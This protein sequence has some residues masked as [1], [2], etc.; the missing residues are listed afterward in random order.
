MILS[1][2]L[3]LAGVNLRIQLGVLIGP[4]GMSFPHAYSIAAW[5]SWIPNLMVATFW[6]RYRSTN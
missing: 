4:I 5:S 3:T 6:I 1:Y 2:A